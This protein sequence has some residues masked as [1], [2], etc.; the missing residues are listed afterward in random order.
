MW[1]EADIH[2]IDGELYVIHDHPENVDETPLLEDLYLQ[3]L[4]EHIEEHDGQVL[5]G[6]T[7]PFYLV[8]DV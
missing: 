1:I 2:L 7:L 6:Q 8:I 5:P 3:P 4:A